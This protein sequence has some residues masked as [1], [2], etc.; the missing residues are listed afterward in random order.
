MQIELAL[1]YI[2]LIR[3]LLTLLSIVYIS[4]LKWRRMRQLAHEQRAST[5]LVSEQHYH[6]ALRSLRKKRYGSLKQ[7]HLNDCIICMAEFKGRDV[8]YE[9]RCDAR[10]YFHKACLEDWL[11][12]KLICP[13]CK[14]PLIREAQM[15]NIGSE[16]F[17]E[18]QSQFSPEVNQ[19]EYGSQQLEPER[20]QR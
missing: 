12:R 5:Q 6:L 18:Q 7:K 4:F 1:G 14:T 3:S 13:L 10:H 8:V 17:I 19:S 2:T 20:E 15:S 16:E 11:K 9:L